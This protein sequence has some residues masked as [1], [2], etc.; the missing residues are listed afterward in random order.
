MGKKRTRCFENEMPTYSTKRKFSLNNMPSKYTRNF[1]S[2][3]YEWEGNGAYL[4]I[5]V[6]SICTI[7]TLLYVNHEAIRARGT[8]IT[9]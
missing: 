8:Y 7:R 5:G 4:V 1:P 3:L 9:I 2:M 6:R